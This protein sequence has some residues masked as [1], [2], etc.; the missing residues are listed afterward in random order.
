MCRDQDHG[1]P[2]VQFKEQAQQR[3]AKCRIDIA[4]R[5]VGQKQFG[6]GYHRAG[7]SGALLLTA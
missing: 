4:C 3:F 1:R 5:F 7:N 2:A 6:L